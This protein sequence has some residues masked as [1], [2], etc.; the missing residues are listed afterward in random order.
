MEQPH[1]T[2]LL[3][4]KNVLITGGSKGIGKAIADAFAAKGANVFIVARKES[5][6]QKAAKEMS[7]TFPSVVVHYAVADLS[8]KQNVGTLA[9]LLQ[10]KHFDVDILVNNAGSYVPGNVTDEPEGNL[11]SMIATNLYS[12]YYLTRA[13]LPD[14]IKNKGHVFNICS[15]ASLKAY[16]GGG[17]YSVSKYA[18]KGFSDN[19]RQEL[20][21]QYVKVTGV[22][23]GAVLTDSWG[24]YDNSDNRIML[25]ADVA[26][27]I[28]AAASLSPQAVVEDIVLRPQLG[29]L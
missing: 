22:Y 16:P 24:D 1:A 2:S 26:D 29:D 10:Q 20:L 12:A 7:N 8:V 21:G 15:I 11:E 3:N 19:L 23:P 14:L 18:M 13:V 6:L 17:S 9:A 28:V 4:G 25:A 27:M 5:D